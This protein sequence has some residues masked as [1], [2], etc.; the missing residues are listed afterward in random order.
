V[1]EGLSEG[2]YEGPVSRRL[3]RV[4]EELESGR[5]QWGE[6]DV[7]ES[8]A[9]LAR[10]LR[11]V[12]ARALER[13]P[14]ASG[15]GDDEGEGLV[16]AAPAGGAG[17]DAPGGGGQE[18]GPAGEAAAGNHQELVRRRVRLVNELIGMLAER[19]EDEDLRDEELVE[20][21][22]I[23]LGIAGKG[24]L[25]D[26]GIPPRPELSLAENALLVNARGEPSLHRELE[27]EIASADRVDLLCSFLKWSGLR[28]V[29]GAL[30]ELIDR[31]GEL[32]V[33]TTCYMGATERRVLDELDAL[34]A[35]VRVS[36]DTRR[37]RLHAKAWLFERATGFST[38]YVG[39]SNLSTAALTDGLEW[40]VRLSEVESAELLGKFRATFEGYWEDPEFEPYSRSRDALR[41]ER[42]RR[43]ELAADGTAEEGRGSGALIHLRPYPFQ[44]EMLDRLHVERTVHDRHRHLIVAAT[45]TGKTIVAALDYARLARQWRRRP[46]LLF[47]AHRQEILEQSRDVFRHALGD[48][49]F[50]ELLVGGHRPERG[51]HVFASVQSLSRIQPADV[52]P[53]AFEVVI[54]DEFHHAKAPTYEVWLDHLRPRELIGLTATPERADGKSVMEWVG[55]AMTVELRL[56]DAIERGLLSP[57]QY[58]GVADG[59]D[60]RDARFWKR[61]GYDL[62]ELEEVYT[63]DD[64]RI[65]KVLDAV[66]ET[67]ADPHRM[68][69]LGFCAGV[70]H[71]ERMADA[72]RQAGLPARALS[73][74]SPDRERRKALR[75]L[76]LRELRCVFTVD[77]FNEGVD[78]PDVDT[79]LLLRPTD[80]A[81]VFLQQ[82]GRGLRRTEHK[83]C[84]TILDFIGF[85]HSKFRFDRRFRALV[86]RASRNGLQRQVQQGFP[87]LPSG[88]AIQLDSQAQEAVLENIRTQ[89]RKDDTALADE[90]KQLGPETT[91]SGLIASTD[92]EPL[93]IYRRPGKGMTSLRRR[94]GFDLPPA[95]PDE[96]RLQAA[97]ARLT[98]WDDLEQLRWTRELFA[99]ERPPDPARFSTLERRRAA[100]LHF[101]LWGVRQAPKSLKESFTR[102]WAEPAIRRE[103]REL[104]EAQTERIDHPAADP[105]ESDPL[106]LR[107]HCRYTR[108]ELLGGFG[109]L[110]PERPHAYQTG[111]IKNEEMGIYWLLVTVQ[112]SEK[113]YSESTM[114]RDYAISPELFHWESQNTTREDSETG[115]DF[116]YHDERG[117]R[118]FLCV[119]E[120]KKDER[121]VTVPYVFL[122]RVRYVSHRSER[123][124]E[125]V[126]RLDHPMPSALVSASK[127]V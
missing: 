4:L 93:E 24:G 74:E 65:R 62:G 43:G 79:V 11:R 97:L 87:W 51:H 116:R 19:T 25:A 76:E 41:F 119:R 3:G 125:I 27:R 38:A 105:E 111:V 78:V 45:G 82:I 20:A 83:D 107:L 108:D 37:T 59:T 14:G 56:W 54:V 80:S 46:S 89:L 6:L 92:L 21:A 95:G 64:A 71:A 1:Q 12:A 86:G 69:A 31:G 47:V 60:L 66:R 61:G 91:L 73:G 2:L 57:F 48:R 67:V 117:K 9:V 22:R 110:N 118:I 8:A 106:P 17:Q 34:G 7:A 81:T 122:G 114:Y 49:E 90:L 53:D 121:G 23:L 88:C 58:F 44:Q 112:K 52:G 85:A 75:Q 101:A 113:E 36:Y 50:G 102:L 96:D 127:L 68:R 33:L 94:A 84:L 124:M 28:L 16:G 26:G 35:E 120:R 123:P 115:L 103:T 30:R 5:A 18:E 109:H 70:R 126:W 77:L 40:N 100:M 98:W 42:A 99:E 104:A 29:R 32:R 55:G 63:G 13:V 10:Y 72:F 39:S 15:P